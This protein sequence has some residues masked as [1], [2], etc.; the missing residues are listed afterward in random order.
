MQFG[1]FPTSPIV[2]IHN[3][4]ANQVTTEADG[5]Q[6]IILVQFLLL[7]PRLSRL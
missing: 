3:L 6:S 1:R 7:K 4:L 5:K 2:L